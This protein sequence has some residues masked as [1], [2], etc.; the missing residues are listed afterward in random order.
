MGRP[1]LLLPIGDRCVLEHVIAAVRQ[2]GV[3]EIVVVAN[4]DGGDLE[5]VAQRSGAHVLRLDEHTPD[6][7][8]TVER[9][10]AWIEENLK[11]TDDDA[12]LL[13]PA[14]HPTIEPRVIGA[15]L[16][17][18]ATCKNASVFIPTFDGRRGHPALIGWKHVTSIRALPPNV[19]LNH[20]FRAVGSQ[21]CEV[22]VPYQSV[23]IDLDTPEDYERLGR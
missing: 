12:W 2:A 4:P 18:Q 22:P 8:T 9:G 20:Y 15:L 19:G 5:V 16:E 17:A 14:D 1:K 7:R 10:L 21:T 3:T 23:L 13:L 11:P 6:M